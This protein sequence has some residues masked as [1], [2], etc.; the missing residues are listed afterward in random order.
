MPQLFLLFSHQLTPEQ[1]ADATQRLKV[2]TFRSLPPDLQAQWSQ[3]PPELEQVDVY[4]QPIWDWLSE[5]AE[6]GDYVMVQGDF[7]IT[8][9]TVRKAL[10]L[11]LVPV[12]ATTRRESSEVVAENGEVRKTLTFRHIRFRKYNP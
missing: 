1:Q 6:G 3:V 8:Y 10:D 5:K 4:A 9:A 7:G 12:Y 2:D 11:G